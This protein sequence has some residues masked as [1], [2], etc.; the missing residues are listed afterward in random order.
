MKRVVN[1]II[2]SN[3][4]IRFSISHVQLLLFVL[5]S[6]CKCYLFDIVHFPY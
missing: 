1:I 4:D 6:Y 2:G 5:L 3:I